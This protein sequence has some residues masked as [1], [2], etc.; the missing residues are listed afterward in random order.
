MNFYWIEV[1]RFLKKYSKTIVLSSLL[2]GVVFTGWMLFRTD[3]TPPIEDAAI[4]EN[5]EIFEGES[6][7]A[8]FRFFIEQ[9]DGYTY[10]NGATVHELFNL[11]EMIDLASEYTSID[12]YEIEQNVRQTTLKEEFTPVN[13]KI[14]S[15]SNILTASFTTGDNE[16][17]LDLAEFY[18]DYLFN[19]G[20]EIL[21]NNL[22]YSVEEPQLLDSRLVM[23]IP[24]SE[25]ELPAPSF[26]LVDTIIDAIIG[27]VFGFVLSMMFVIAKEFFSNKLNFSFT[28]TTGNP[29]NFILY[30]AKYSNKEFLKK[31]I[32]LPLVSNKI[33]VSQSDLLNK[34]KLFLSNEDNMEL[35]Q[36]SSL[37]VLPLGKRVDEIIIAVHINKTDRKWYNEQVEF[38]KL[39]KVPVK[40]I[41]I[42]DE[43]VE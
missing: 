15:S 31:F 7:P 34:G 3:E 41:Q 22:L 42:N 24:E 35:E 25:T 17:N 5:T 23:E 29:D 43:E 4:E 27:V 12:L 30:D 10:T 8:H 28:Y 13:V 26:S 21:D 11:P 33:L 38:S 1:K 6:L 18:Y 14:D 36:Y 20:F 19:E 9:E 32:G 37:S 39:H 40:I 16:D 2:F